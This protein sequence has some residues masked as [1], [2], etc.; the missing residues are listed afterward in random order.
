VKKALAIFMG[1]A[2][3]GTAFAV[4]VKAALQID[5]SAYGTNGTVI[6]DTDTTDD[7]LLTFS[8]NG[9]NAGAKFTIHGKYAEDTAY[10]RYGS[11]WFKPI[12]QVKFTVGKTGWALT[13]EQIEWWRGNKGTQLDGNWNNNDNPDTST[14]AIVE[15]NPIPALNLMLGIDDVMQASSD[16]KS[17]GFGKA[18][19][20]AVGG[21]YTIDNIGIIGAAYKHYG[22]VAGTAAKAATVEAPAIADLTTGIVTPA[23]T[24]ADAVAATPDQDA[25]VIR[26]S[27]QLTA[28][29]DLLAFAK[30]TLRQ[31]IAAVGESKKLNGIGVD[32]YGAYN[33][34]K[35]GIKAFVP[36]VKRL[37][38]NN[39][40]LSMYYDVRAQYA[41]TGFTPYIRLRDTM[42]LSGDV[43]VN[44][45]VANEAVNPDILVAATWNI[46]ALSFD[47]GFEY[48]TPVWECSPTTLVLRRWRRGMTNMIMALAKR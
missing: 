40:S 47:C 14:S 22:Y 10:V 29:K 20:Y 34:D 7:D 42:K 18:T 30:L 37:D 4:D 24:K 31:D 36:V 1:L 33:V 38:T 44:N 43:A 13:T 3:V 15:V 2:L 19:P 9:T 45:T 35:F 21:K 48:A 41:L 28:V 5:G 8:V 23:T 25:D 17:N 11:L 46:E 16:G 32:L 6:N 27:F 39:Q 26:A 12:D